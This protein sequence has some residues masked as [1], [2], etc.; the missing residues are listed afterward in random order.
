[1]QIGRIFLS[2][3]VSDEWEGLSVSK[4][5]FSACWMFLSDFVF[6]AWLRPLFQAFFHFS[7]WTSPSNAFLFFDLTANWAFL[8]PTGTK[9]VN[10]IWWFVVV[11]SRRTLSVSSAGL[12]AY[13]SIEHLPSLLSLPWVSSHFLLLYRTFSPLFFFLRKL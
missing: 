6:S 5:H 9:Y 10:I 2:A 4:R 7:F 12:R 1:M 8:E 13:E 3:E 11:P